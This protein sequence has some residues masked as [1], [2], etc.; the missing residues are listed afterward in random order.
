MLA[1]HRK[2]RPCGNNKRH[3]CGGFLY[4]FSIDVLPMT[5]LLFASAQRLARPASVALFGEQQL[6]LPQGSEEAS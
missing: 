4:D 3:Y 6:C 5:E 2:E 1:R